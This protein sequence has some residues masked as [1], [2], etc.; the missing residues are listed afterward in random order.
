MNV[1]VRHMSKYRKHWALKA[2]DFDIKILARKPVSKYFSARLVKV[3]QLTRD[4]R[5]WEVKKEPD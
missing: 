2:Y 3:L 1:K 4:V 5:L